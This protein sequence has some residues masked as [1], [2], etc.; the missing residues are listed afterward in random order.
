MA[1][2]V[3]GKGATWAFEH[4]LRTGSTS[5]TRRSDQAMQLALDRM[6]RV[7][8]LRL[9]L[10]YPALTHAQNVFPSSGNVGI[11]TATPRAHLE[12]DGGGA[13]IRVQTTSTQNPG[14]N[15]YD[16]LGSLKASMGFNLGTN[17]MLFGH[18]GNAHLNIN[19]SGWVGVG[20][21]TP[22][23]L[24]HV[25]GNAQVDGNIAAKY[26]D[27]A[28]WVK[29]G[30]DVPAGTVVVIDPQAPDRAMTS[31]QAY[32]TR[33]AGVVSARPGLL[34]GEEGPDKAKI[35]HSGRVKVKVDARYGAIRTGDLLVCSPTPGYAMR[36]EPVIVGGTSMHRPGTLIGKALEPLAGGESEIL[37]LLILQ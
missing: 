13:T 2:K 8:P 36:S 7:L 1:S 35:A 23:A 12:V 3:Q 15:F 19:S 17:T 11:G 24:L 21:A 5:T 22:A 25:A 18:S 10:S 30:P 29:A 20:T 4:K 33:V 32:D 37:V 31:S 28:E 16:S 26:Q 34:L 6:V 9:L 27:V 14:L